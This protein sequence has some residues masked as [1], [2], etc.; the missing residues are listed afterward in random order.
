M[1]VILRT[2]V[3]MSQQIVKI[4]SI[5]SS[6][7]KSMS[8]HSKRPCSPAMQFFQGTLLLSEHMEKPSKNPP[9]WESWRSNLQKNLLRIVLLRDPYLLKDVTNFTVPNSRPLMQV[10]I[11]LVIYIYM[12]ACIH[13][14]VGMCVGGWWDIDG[15]AEGVSSCLG[16]HKWGATNEGLRGA[17]PPSLKGL[18]RA[19]FALFLPFSPFSGARK[20]APGNSKNAGKRPFFLRYPWICLSP[21]S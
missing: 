7:R 20:K 3:R 17:W 12:C 4:V 10:T 9:P 2:W 11:A 14:C 16:C 6:L 1:S 18:F 15:P 21:V 13:M 19:F 5:C 8:L